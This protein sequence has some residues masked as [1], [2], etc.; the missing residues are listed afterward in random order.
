MGLAVLAT[1]R[2][3]ANRLRAALA[4]EIVDRIR[5]AVSSKDVAKLRAASHRLK[6]SSTQLGATALASDCRELELMGA[7]QELERAEEVLKK[8]ERDF[9]AACDALQAELAKGEERAA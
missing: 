6:S 1:S 8:L 9:A 3:L 5:R 2:P 4:P 7:G